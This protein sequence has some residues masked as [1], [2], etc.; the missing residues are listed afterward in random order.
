MQ[1][2][3]NMLLPSTPVATAPGGLAITPDG[4]QVYI[5]HYTD[6][7]TPNLTV[8][9]TVTGGV[10]RL[11]VGDHPAVFG[12]FIGPTAT[13][14]TVSADVGITMIA[15]GAAVSGGFINYTITVGNTGPSTA[16]GVVVTTDTLNVANGL[17]FS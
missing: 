5:P 14:L 13:A 3:T 1:T 4:T 17:Q 12:Q 15:N 10:A 16:T 8:V 11:T 9:D 2:S 6:T 7:S